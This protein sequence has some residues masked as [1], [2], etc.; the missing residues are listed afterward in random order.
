[1]SHNQIDQLGQNLDFCVEK[2]NLKLCDVVPKLITLNVS[3]N[4]L[5]VR[6]EI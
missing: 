3:N 6:F 5:Q 1:M 4:R 2:Q